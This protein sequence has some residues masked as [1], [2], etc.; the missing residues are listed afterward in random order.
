MG[1]VTSA[2]GPEYT[3]DQMQEMNEMLPEEVADFLKAEEAF[4][5]ARNST[6]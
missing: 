5:R 3:D 1:K 2:G 6:K 4:Y